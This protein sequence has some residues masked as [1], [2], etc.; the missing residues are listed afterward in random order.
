MNKS[1]TTALLLLTSGF[2]LNT[3]A[4]AEPLNHGSSY[5]NV[6]V[7]AHSHPKFE[8][9]QNRSRTEITVA[10]NGFNDH[11]AI[12]NEVGAIRAI[13]EI[14]TSVSRMLSSIVNGFNDRG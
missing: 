9:V 7:Q 1:M 10:T 6:V 5:V 12:E 13:S 4:F 8:S 3:A 14:E 11:G 2:T